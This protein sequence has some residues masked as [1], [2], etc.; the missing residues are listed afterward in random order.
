MSFAL[1]GY[2][3]SVRTST[4]ATTFSLVYGMEVVLPIEVEIPSLRVLMEA[5]FDEAKWIRGRYEQLNFVE[6]KRLAA[7][8]HGQ[9][10]QRRLMR[11]YNKKFQLKGFEKET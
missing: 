11:A 5:K 10:Y 3:T 1:H 8:S 2:R 7:L 6:E 9:L 4:G